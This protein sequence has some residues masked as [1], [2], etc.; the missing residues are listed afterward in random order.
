M[1]SRA[2]PGG[3]PVLMESRASVREKV[4][5]EG[6]RKNKNERERER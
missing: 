1:A 5:K 6:K 3:K 2:T 4:E